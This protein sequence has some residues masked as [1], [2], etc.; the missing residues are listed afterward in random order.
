MLPVVSNTIQI[1]VVSNVLPVVGNVA[2]AVFVVV[3]IDGASVVA[4][5]V[6]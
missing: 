5:S 4:L 1:L 3:S 2:V 6:I